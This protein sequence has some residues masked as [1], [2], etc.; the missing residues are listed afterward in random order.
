MPS[1]SLVRQFGKQRKAILDSSLSSPAV[2]QHVGYTTTETSNPRIGQESKR[3]NVFSGSG[4]SNSHGLSSH[5]VALSQRMEGVSI[6]NMKG[7]MMSNNHV[8]ITTNYYGSKASFEDSDAMLRVGDI[9]LE[10]EI[11]SYLDANNVWRARYKGQIMTSSTLNMSIWSYR[12]EGA[13]EVH[14]FYHPRALTNLPRNLKRPIKYM[15]HC[16]VIWYL[17]LPTPHS[18]SIPCAPSLIYRPEYYKM[19]PSSQWI[20]HYLKLPEQSAHSMLEA[21]NLRGYALQVSDVD[22]SG[23]LV[24]AHFIRGPTDHSAFDP[25]ICTA[26]E[27]NTFIKED[28]LAYCKFLFDMMLLYFYH[29]TSTLPSPLD[30]AAP[31][32]LSHPEINLPVYSLPGWK[33]VVNKMDTTVEDAA[34]VLKLLPSM[35]IRYRFQH[36][37]SLNTWKYL[38]KM[39]RHYLQPGPAR[40]TISSMIFLS[41]SWIYKLS[42]LDCKDTESPG[43]N[44]LL[45]TEHLY[46]FCPLKGAGNI[47]WSQ[48]EAGQ[49][50]IEDLLIQ[51]AFGIT[52][53]CDWE[54]YLYDIPPQYYEILRT[55]HEACGFDP[56][57]TQVAKYIGLPLV[58]TDGGHSALEEYV[59]DSEYTSESE[60]GDS[61]YESASEDVY[62]VGKKW[63]DESCVKKD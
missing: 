25:R 7:N 27:T 55:I 12:G 51:A 21:H 33:K 61:N 6:R 45:E 40:Q 23:R 58:V 2:A 62:S 52:V 1:F 19:L 54:T 46:L 8:H 17:P 29:P 59:E 38:N 16:L 50:I 42:I 60:S 4:A 53:H 22:E 35:T 48:D 5:A 43:L 57:S 9:H 63:K 26:F 41:T 18:S 37:Q 32:Q 15:H 13:K 39:M 20:P 3:G 11:E 24:I 31:F 36:S 34:I 28:L 10:E 49:N 56:Y 14:S 47:Y 30:K 44:N